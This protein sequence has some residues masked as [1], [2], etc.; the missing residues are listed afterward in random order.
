MV[1]DTV[2]GLV[3]GLI[4]LIILL[5]KRIVEST[6]ALTLAAV[7]VTNTVYETFLV[8]LLA[9]GLVEF[10]RT[11]WNRSDLSYYLRATQIRA[12][13]DYKDIRDFKVAIQEEISKVNYFKELVSYFYF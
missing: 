4:I 8:C 9:F 6:D 11:L 2:A 5:S 1:V 10:P 3:A 12:T 7:I 13:Y